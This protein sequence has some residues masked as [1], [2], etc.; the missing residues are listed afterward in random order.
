MSVRTAK[1]EGLVGCRRCALAWPDAET[2]C[3]RCGARLE[4]RKRTSLAAVWTLWILGVLAYIPANL[5]PM[6][7]TRVLF[8][9]SAE[10]ILGGAWTLARHGSVGVA[11]VIV[12]ASV[13]IP[14]TKFAAIAWLA[15]AAGRRTATSAAARHKVY[16]L[17]ELVGR[18]SMVDVFV[19]AILS[20]LVQFSVVASVRPGPAAAA[21][22]L[23]VVF[24]MLSARGFDSRLIWDMDS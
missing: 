12:A 23:S 5:L 13:L 8:R 24:T 17:I 3:G 11:L 2:H 9:T 18:W 20:S 19:V 21:F 4:S 7:E 22:A 6:L 10:T 15:L 1:A 16:H 14:L